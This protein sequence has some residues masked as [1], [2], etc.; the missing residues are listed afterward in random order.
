MIYSFYC[1]VRLLAAD[2]N[3]S[4]ADWGAAAALFCFSDGLCPFNM[5]VSFIC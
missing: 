1:V 2:C 3:A 4:G 5:R